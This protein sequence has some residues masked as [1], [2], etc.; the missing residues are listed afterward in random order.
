MG[1]L[2]ECAVSVFCDD[3]LK[4][5]F[6]VLWRIFQFHYGAMRLWREA[7]PYRRRHSWENVHKP[8]GQNIN[9]TFQVFDLFKSFFN[10]FQP[11]LFT[12][13]AGLSE[14]YNCEQSKMVKPSKKWPKMAEKSQKF[15]WPS[16][17]TF[18]QPL[19]LFLTIFEPLDVHMVYE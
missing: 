5:H 4:R 10:H 3:L 6:W 19:W 8:F 17:I 9:F 15:S 12:F 7:F 13:F 16:F 1:D 2:V 14:H 11:F 18:D